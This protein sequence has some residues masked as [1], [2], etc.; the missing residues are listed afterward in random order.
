MEF[1]NLPFLIGRIFLI[2]AQALIVFACYFYMQIVYTN[3]ILPDKLVSENYV[4]TSCTVLSKNMAQVGRF[5][6]RYRADFMV[7]YKAK[8]ATYQTHVTGNGLDQGYFHD[9]GPQ[10]ETLALFNVGENYPCWYNPE[11]P[12]LAVLVMRHNW[13]STLP[14]MVPTAIG[15]IAIYYLIKGLFQFFGMIRDSFQDKKKRYK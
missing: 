9:R 12:Q 15:L 11:V 3:N 13:M 7:S 5:V 1:S 2:I 10:E 4:E 14:L 6:H 8:D